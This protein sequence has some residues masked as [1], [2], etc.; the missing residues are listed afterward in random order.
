MKNKILYSILLFSSLYFEITNIYAQNNVNENKIDINTDI[1]KFEKNINHAIFSKDT[2][3]I[4]NSYIEFCNYC[5]NIGFNS[6]A[7]NYGRKA[8]EYSSLTNNLELINKS[9]I[10]TILSYINSI[11]FYQC[12]ITD[13]VDISKIND[14]LDS[15]KCNQENEKYILKCKILINNILENNNQNNIDKLYSLDSL[16]SDTQLFIKQIKAE[17]EFYNKNYITSI[18]ILNN[19]LNI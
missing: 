5:S 17:I 11:E 2:N 18:S 3:L 19:I 14:F 9:Y 8:I 15:V 6:L 12:N 13:S 7:E 10:S 1:S 4:I 16:N